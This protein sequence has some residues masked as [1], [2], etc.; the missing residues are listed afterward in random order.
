MKFYVTKAI[1]NIFKWIFS[2]YVRQLSNALFI[3]FVISS[4]VLIFLLHY[5]FLV[6]STSYDKAAWLL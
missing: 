2:T 4:S 3:C 1:G 6:I 5:W